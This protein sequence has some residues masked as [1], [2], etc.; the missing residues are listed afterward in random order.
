M[1]DGVVSPAVEGEEGTSC[2]FV[3]AFLTAALP[4]R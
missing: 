4:V 2:A 3:P 1:T